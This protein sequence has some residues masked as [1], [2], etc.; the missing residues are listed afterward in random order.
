M[1][2][3]FFCF[4]LLNF[5][6]VSAQSIEWFEGSLVL[7]NGEVL[8]GKISLES[9]HDLVLFEQRD[10]R[11]VYPAHKI[12]SLYFYDEDHDINRRFISLK[13]DD[14]VRSAH[15]LYE[16]VISGDVSVMRRKKAGTYAVGSEP[17]DYN[18][19]ISCQEGVMPLKKFKR[20]IYPTL[21]AKSG[22]RLAGFVTKNRLHADLP[23]NAI[24]IIE[25]HNGLVQEHERYANI[26]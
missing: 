23:V 9:E 26:N 7:T 19:F 14:E 13:E 6:H 24:R 8:V 15:Q 2:K 18:Y 5:H 22:D 16:I 10:S 17:Y 21:K 3:I 4:L 20:K 12:K 11:M 1:K 25:Y